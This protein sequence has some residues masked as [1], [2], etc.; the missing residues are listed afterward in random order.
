MRA[1]G[2]FS[3]ATDRNLGRI[4][5]EKLKIEKLLAS[6]PK[7]VRFGLLADSKNILKRG[8]LAIQT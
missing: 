4:S 8:I 3:F 2:G 7:Q 6:Y 5:G 1:S